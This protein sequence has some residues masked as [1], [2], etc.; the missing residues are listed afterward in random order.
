MRKTHLFFMFVFC[1]FFILICHDS[2][3]A[4]VQVK[5]KIKLGTKTLQQ[6]IH[7]AALLDG[8]VVIELEGGEY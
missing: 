4:I 1:L 3:C 6:A 5:I 7:K 8:D 2:C